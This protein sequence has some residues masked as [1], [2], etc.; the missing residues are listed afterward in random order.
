LSKC[1]LK[2]VAFHHIFLITKS[3]QYAILD[4]KCLKRR[5]LNGY[6]QRLLR[7]CGRIGLSI[8]LAMRKITSIYFMSGIMPLIRTRFMT[9]KSLEKLAG[10]LQKQSGPYVFCHAD[11][12]PANLI[13]DSNGHVFKYIYFSSHLCYYF[14]SQYIWQSCEICPFPK[15]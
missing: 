11:L 10:V 14:I 5:S 2:E 9:I 8:P 12:H 6:Y 13:R 7:L 4:T 1:N 3:F 15:V